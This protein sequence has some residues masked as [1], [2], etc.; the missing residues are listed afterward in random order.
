MGGVAMIGPYGLSILVV[1]ALAMAATGWVWPL[2]M[3]L[4]VMMGILVGY[5]WNIPNRQYGRRRR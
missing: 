1:L 5:I 4:G 2:A 3:W